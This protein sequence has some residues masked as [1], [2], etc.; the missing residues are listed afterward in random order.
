MKILFVC[1]YNRFR[2]KVAEA[3]LKSKLKNKDFEIIS[4]GLIPSTN[5]MEKRELKVVNKFGIDVRA[6]PRGIN[7]RKVFWA[8]L[9]IIVADNIPKKLFKFHNHNIKVLKWR[10]KDFN[11]GDSEEKIA[12]TIK[13]IIKKVDRL[14]ERELK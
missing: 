5:G 7:T 9:I 2:S 14:V 10:I 13:Q 11:P 6:K 4:A 12:D 8:D 1:K 3:Y